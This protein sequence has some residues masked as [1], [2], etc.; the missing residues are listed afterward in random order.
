VQIRTRLTF[1]FTLWVSTIVLLSFLAIYLFSKQFAEQDFARR[2][3]ERA[4]TSAILLIKVDQVDSLLLKVIDRAKRDNLFR[5]RIRVYDQ[6]DKEIYASGDTMKLPISEQILAQVKLKGELQ[7][8]F[9]EFAIAGIPFKDRDTTYTILASAEDVIGYNRLVDLR[10]LLMALFIIVMGLVFIS[11]WIYSG[12]ALRPIQKIITNVQNISPQNL[13]QRLEESPHPDEMGKL[14][15]IF[16]GLLAR[17]E[18]AFKLQKMFVSNVSHELKNPL[19]NITSQ[20]EVTLLNERPRE[21]YQRTIESVLEDIKSLNHLS[22]S[23]LDLARLT[24]DSDTFTMAEVRL[25]EILWDAR[26]HVRAIDQN[27]KVEVIIKDMPDDENRLLVNG[28]PHLLRTAFQNV[29]ENA[30]KFSEDGRAEVTLMCKAEALVVEVVDRGPGIEE[31]DLEHVFQPFFR[32][33][34]TSKVKGYGVGLSLSQRI[35]S[36]HKGEIS[37]DSNPGKGTRIFVTIQPAH[38][39]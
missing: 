12:R 3:R 13:S 8:V 23:L 6:A 21:E 36:I 37:I 24:H 9:N 4:I 16:N 18:N 22:V 7:T 32:T 15:L 17:I 25:D 20:L 33:D 31:K 26:E 19:T 11:G 35:I 28:N 34:A 29:I 38:G 2:L 39:F 10:R 14:I 1:Q 5:E 27:Y 30:C